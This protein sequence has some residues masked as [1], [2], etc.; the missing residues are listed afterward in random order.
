MITNKNYM[1]LVVVFAM[2]YG[3]YTALGAIIDNIATSYK[4]TSK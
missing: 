4:Y 3:V 2:L 1:L